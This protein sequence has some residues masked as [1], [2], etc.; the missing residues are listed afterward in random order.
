MQKLT[1][2]IALI[3]SGNL[4]VAQYNDSISIQL[5][6]EIKE[7]A[8]ENQ[9]VGFSVAIYNENE[10]LYNKGFGYSDK[11]QKKEYTKNTIQNIGSTSKTFIALALLKAQELGVLHLDDSINKHLPFKVFNPYF[12]KDIITIRQLTSHTS[13]IR[14]RDWWYGLNCY[15]LK[16]GKTKNQKKSIGVSK[17]N[18]MMSMETLYKNYLVKGGGFYKKKSF[19]KYKPGTHYEYS[20]IAAALGAYILEQATG[21]DFR[22]FTQKYIFNPLEMNDTGWSFD[23]VPMEKH[24]HLYTK[25]H[26]ELALYS[27]VTYPDGGLITSASDMAKYSIELLKVSQGNGKLLSVESYEEAYT[28][29]LNKNH[30]NGELKENSGVFFD[31]RTNGEIGHGGSD[32]GVSTLLYYNHKTKTGSYLQ[33]NTG[34]NKKS[35][36]QVLFIWKKLKEYE[37]FFN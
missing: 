8:N 2:I 15:I 16:E 30:F 9:F 29:V 18:K 5:T 23:D 11:S 14:D 36:P 31:I 4:L 19:S 13:S 25:S 22:D 27:L 10:I 1:I 26:K 7:F 12:P 3:F 33:I 32:P 35:V 17:P 24:T 34:V 21:Q 37:G 28:Q 20:N 6:K